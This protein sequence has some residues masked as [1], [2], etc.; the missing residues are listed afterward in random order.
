MDAR[1]SDLPIRPVEY[2][3]AEAVASI[4]AEAFAADPVMSWTLGGTGRALPLFRTLIARV[5]LRRGFGHIADDGDGGAGATLWLPP[6]E[7][8]APEG[9]D[10][11]RLLWAVLWAGG[12]G[13]LARGKTVGDAMAK[14]HPPRPHYYLF[15]VGVRDAMKGRGLGG[16]LIREGLARAEAD[17]ADAYLENSNPLNTPLYQRLGFAAGEPLPL[18]D[19]AP[20]LLAMI[21]ERTEAR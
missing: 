15:A 7:S 12:P 8:S 3:D 9:F 2:G 5:Y 19:G 16:R 13:A 17:G 10:E 1:A 6:G 4:L 20:P 11:L 14:H 21:R 18:P